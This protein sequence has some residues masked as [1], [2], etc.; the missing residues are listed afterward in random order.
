MLN[1]IIPTPTEFYSILPLLAAGAA[2]GAGQLLASVIKKKQANAMIPPEEDLQQRS[3]LN[4]IRNK[5]LQME[6]GAGTAA[7]T[8][9]GLTAK[10]MAQTQSNIT[11]AAGGNLGATLSGLAMSQGAAGDTMNKVLAEQQQQSAAYMQLQNQLQN[12]VSQRKFSLQMGNYLQK[13]RESSELRQEGLGNLLGGAVGMLGQVGGL[14]G[15]GAN[16]LAGG[17]GSKTGQGLAGVTKGLAGVT[18]YLSNIFSNRNTQ[19]PQ[20]TTIGV[21]NYAGM[22]PRSQEGTAEVPTTL[23]EMYSSRGEQYDPYNRELMQDYNNIPWWQI[24][25]KKNFNNFI[26]KSNE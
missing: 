7:S 25:R 21:S 18:N 23:S 16:A 19:T 4:E 11:R 13:L 10:Q 12:E 6:R 14:S 8:A 22:I 2:M 9:R 17:A 5:R 26:T 15:A 1:I 20:N 3:M 24:Q